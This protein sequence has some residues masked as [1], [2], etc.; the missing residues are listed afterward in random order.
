MF[1]VVEQNVDIFSSYCHPQTLF[2]AST[3]KPIQKHPLNLR[4]GESI[5]HTGP[6]N[7]YQR[8]V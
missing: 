1:Y 7:E 4:R 5:L 3:G 6:L 2:E 8:Y